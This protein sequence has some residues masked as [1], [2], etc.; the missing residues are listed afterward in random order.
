MNKIHVS[1]NVKD[2]KINNAKTVVKKNTLY[3]FLSG[4]KKKDR[5]M[6]IMH[7]F[8]DQR[9]CVKFSYHHYMTSLLLQKCSL[10]VIKLV[11][12]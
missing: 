4:N 2:W 3:M 9:E 8:P 6:K 1:R 11:I 7:F 12:S 5:K 10:T